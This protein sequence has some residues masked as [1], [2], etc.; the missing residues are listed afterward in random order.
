[1]ESQYA[2]ADVATKGQ[3]DF[4]FNKSL[5]RGYTSTNGINMCYWRKP[6]SIPV[7][8]LHDDNCGV[9]WYCP[10]IPFTGKDASTT[11]SICKKFCKKHGFELNI[12]FLFIS[13][14]SLDIT[15]AICYNRSVK[16]EDKRAL[17]CHNEIMEA[18][19]KK[20]YSPYRLGIQ[21]MHLMK[22]RKRSITLFTQRLKKA[23]DPSNV[24]APGHYIG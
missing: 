24:L 13:Q 11:I 2:S 18:L 12:G 22:Q 10:T 21:S 4:M 5:L 9:L 7:T 6:V 19:A 3:L 1:V 20:G 16:G 8:E 15:G 23:I 17:K 14:R